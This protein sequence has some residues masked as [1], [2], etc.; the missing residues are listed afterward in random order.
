MGDITDLSKRNKAFRVRIVISRAGTI[1][2][3][4]TPEVT[5]M[6]TAHSIGRGLKKKLGGDDYDIIPIVS[7]LG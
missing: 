4:V 3:K 6:G 7:E 1:I 2:K 5:D